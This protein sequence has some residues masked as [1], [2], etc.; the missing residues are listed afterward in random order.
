MLIF[1]VMTKYISN[2]QNIWTVLCFCHVYFI[3][4]YCSFKHQKL[5]Q[6][7]Q[8]QNTGKA[9]RRV[10]LCYLSIVERKNH[11]DL[12]CVQDLQADDAAHKSWHAALP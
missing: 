1:F 6:S 8:F 3:T 2:I 7:V 10:L 4:A 5:T 12:K 11:S 9:E